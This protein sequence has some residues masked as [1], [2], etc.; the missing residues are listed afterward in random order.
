M[1]PSVPIV[2]TEW[3]DPQKVAQMEDFNI[4]EWDDLINSIDEI[5][6][7]WARDEEVDHLTRGGHHFKPPY[8]DS[9]NPLGELE[10]NRHLDPCEE[11]V[12]LRQLMKT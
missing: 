9:N 5:D 8:L 3:N 1:T 2:P 12:V 4:I 7:I 10:A 11:E 6:D